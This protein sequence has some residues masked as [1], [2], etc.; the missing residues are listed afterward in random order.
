MNA[1]VPRARHLGRRMVVVA[2]LS[3]NVATGFMFGSFG[4]LVVPIERQMHVDRGLSSA[5]AALVILAIGV[6]APFI[7]WLI[8]TCGL[9]WMMIAGAL[10][11]S[12][13]Y[14]TAGLASD[15][16]V[17]LLAYGLMIGPGVAL[18]GLSVPT[19]LVSNWFVEGRGKA[20]GIVNMPIAVA[21]VPPVMALLLAQ[22]GLSATY[23]V[24]AVGSL[25]LTPALF[26]VVERPDQA[27]VNLWDDKEIPIVVAPLG[28][29]E[30]LRTRDYR[31]L[32]FSAAMMAGGGAM[33]TTHII[34]LAIGEGVD[35]PL[36]ALLLSLL[37][38][39]GV[40]GSLA[41][42]ALADRFG[43]PRAMVLNATC[44]A[45]LWAGFLVPMDFV[46]RAL[47]IV[48]IGINSGGMIT[49]IGTALSQRFG[50]AA[51]GAALGLWSLLNLPFAVGMP[52]LAGFL[53][54]R[55]HGYSAAF[56]L[57]ICLFAV[58]AVLAG[59]V[60]RAG[61]RRAATSG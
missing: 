61:S 23:M 58:A 51:L 18:L 16:T 57:Q 33:L 32:A 53:F 39:A 12:A 56:T 55:F 36:A 35:P 27:S 15:I 10:L 49:C 25:L 14:A 54:E 9:K 20:I 38:A 7:G 21:L 1:E 5:G 47:L 37:G 31:R 34:S 43:G 60:A 41:Y 22:L 59:L 46:P 3:Q 26:L 24:L 50:P 48:L 6:I 30:L 45:F 44:Q 8:R 11:C 28:N 19:T 4:A 13:G 29:V 2:A 40:A 52:P 42:G 17:L